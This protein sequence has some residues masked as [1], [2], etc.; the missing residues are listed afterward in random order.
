VTFLSSSLFWIALIALLVAVVYWMARRVNRYAR[1]MDEAVYDAIAAG[2]IGR[3]NAERITDVW[4][5]VVC[6]KG[7]GVPFVRL[8]VSLDRLE[9]AKRVSTFFRLEPERGRCRYA[10]I[11]EMCSCNLR[12]TAVR[13][14]AFYDVH[15]KWH[16]NKDVQMAK[17]HLC[18]ECA[19]KYGAWTCPA[20]GRYADS[21]DPEWHWTGGTWQHSHAGE[22]FKAIMRLAPPTTDIRE[23]E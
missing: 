17:G 19:R 13:L 18:R 12:E 7:L 15:G 8:L 16:W 9:A 4:Y 22:K 21:T 11:P 5:R 3:R 10:Y 14:D 20:C 6:D 2:G 1:A 23:P